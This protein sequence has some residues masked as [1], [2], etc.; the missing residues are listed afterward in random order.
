MSDHSD[1]IL[2]AHNDDCKSFSAKEIEQFGEDL[3]NPHTDIELKNRID[4]NQLHAL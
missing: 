1:Y 2:N 3:V 4:E